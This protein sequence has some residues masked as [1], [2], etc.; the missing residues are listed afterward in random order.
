MQ[1]FVPTPQNRQRPRACRPKPQMIVAAAVS[2][3]QP[4]R[5]QRHPAAGQVNPHGVSVTRSGSTQ[6]A[7]VHA[8]PHGIAATRTAS[9]RQTGVTATRTGTR[10]PALGQANPHGVT[11]TRTALRAVAPDAQIPLQCHPPWKSE[12]RSPVDAEH[13]HGVS[14]A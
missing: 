1:L 9:M 4:A 2:T 14:V 11:V 13:A 10:Q 8:N 6:P 7:R 12:S 5:G 3:P